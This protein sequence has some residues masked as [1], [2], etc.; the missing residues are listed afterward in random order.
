M[1]PDKSH[2]L[3]ALLPRNRGVLSVALVVIVTLCLLPRFPQASEPDKS[4]SDNKAGVV[5]AFVVAFNAQD[6][7]A[8]AALVTAD[9][10]WIYVNRTALAVE[11]EGK[12]ALIKSMTE[13]FSGCPTCRSEIHGMICSR[14]RVSVVEVASWESQAGT[15]SQAAMAVYEFSGE[16]IRTVY[17]FPEESRRPHRVVASSCGD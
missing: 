12:D 8:M 16:L 6:V 4:E 1:P 7:A 17:Y 10:R 2:G 11:L 13:Y 5:R 3:S 15:R 9:I 14:E